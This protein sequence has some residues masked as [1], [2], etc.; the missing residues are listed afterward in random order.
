MVVYTQD[1][2]KGPFHYKLHALDITTGAEKFGGPA[3]IQATYPGNGDGSVNGILT[4]DPKMQMQR[5]SL[6]LSNG[7]LYIAF[8]SFA[9]T[10]PYHGCPRDADVRRLKRKTNSLR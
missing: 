9:D 4:F 10:D 1:S 7:V 6:L 5:P 3:E 2:S 8:G